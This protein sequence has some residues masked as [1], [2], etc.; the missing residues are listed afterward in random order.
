[1]RFAFRHLLPDYN[2][3]RRLGFLL[4]LWQRVGLKRFLGRL[5]GKVKVGWLLSTLFNW[6]DLLPPLPDFKMLPRQS[7][8]TGEK[9]GQINLFT[10]CVMD[11]LYND[12]NH[13]CQRLLTRQRCLVRVGEQTCCGALAYH[14][15][16]I[17]IARQLACQNIELSESSSGEIVV[18]AAGCSAVLKHYPQLFAGSPA[19]RQR[20]E[21]FSLRVRDITE[22]L[23]AT[24]WA[25][26]PGRLELKVAYH[27]AC[28]LAHAQKVREAPLRLLHAIPGLTLIPLEEEE[29]CCGS[30]GIFNLTHTELS[31]AV[32]ARKI[33]KIQATGAD[34]VV[35]SNPGCQLQL[36]YGVRSQRLPLRVVHIATLLDEAF[37]S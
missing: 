5:T 7:W 4:S 15:G 13:A 1:M 35:T 32:L 12:V 37:C 11:I 33:S 22:A 14:A 20:A 36:A 10:G 16:E 19:W 34:V 23:D 30:A 25:C 29:H 17:D 8:V 9:R 28:H 31:L 24:Q 27:A 2:K 6:Q 21:R 26:K 3:L 18:T